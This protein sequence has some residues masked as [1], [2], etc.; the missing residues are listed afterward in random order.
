MDKLIED[1]QIKGGIFADLFTGTGSVADHFKD[2]FEILTN[3]L[4]Y[5]ASIFSKAKINFD[6]I[7]DF[8][9]FEKCFSLNPFEYWNSYDFSKEPHGFV[10]LNFS[11]L[12]NRQ[13][14]QEKN[15]IKIDTIR[16]QI[17]KFRLDKIFNEN[18]YS[19][20]LA[21]L[22]ESVMRVSNTSGTYEAFFKNWESRSNK[23]FLFT[24]LSIEKRKVFSSNNRTYNQDAN[25]LVRE[26]EG[27]VAYIDTP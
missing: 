15:A 7:P 6:N 14:F 19:F 4:L 13:F 23:D 18:E 21:S 27:D 8:T 2:R 20:L 11:P 16:R 22:L 25:K 12:G 26:I 1:K 5:Y 17:E 3:D 9:N 24:P 10:S